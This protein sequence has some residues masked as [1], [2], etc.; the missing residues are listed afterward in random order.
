M[1]KKTPSAVVLKK[2][3][4]AKQKPEQVG[5]IDL[6]NHNQVEDSQGSSSK[7]S[8]LYPCTAETAD[9]QIKGG[10]LV[11][12]LGSLEYIPPEIR[13]KQ[14]PLNGYDSNQEHYYDTSVDHVDDFPSDEDVLESLLDALELEKNLLVDSLVEVFAPVLKDNRDPVMQE[15]EQAIQ[16]QGLSPRGNKHKKEW[17]ARKGINDVPEAKQNKVVVAHSPEVSL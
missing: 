2:M 16:Q 5:T 10:K 9:L 14:D 15:T 6:A 13:E 1:K 4:W 7:G 8:R 12:D 11:V 17:K 3:L